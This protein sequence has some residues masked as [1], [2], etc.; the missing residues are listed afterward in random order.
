MLDDGL[1]RKYL[2]V[3]DSGHPR[4]SFLDDGIFR[5]TPPQALNDPFEVKPRVLLDEFADE[6]WAVARARG[7]EAG[8]SPD[9]D[10]TIRTFLLEAFP[11]QRFD[12][13][14][15]PGLYPA[16]I[17]ELRNEP[18]QTVAEIDAFRAA[19]ICATVEQ[20][21]N[22]RIG[23]FSWA[24][25]GHEHR[26]IVVGFDPKHPFLNAV[27]E[28]HQVEYRALHVA[29]SSNGELIRVAGYPLNGKERVPVQT[30]LRKSPEWAYEKEWRLLVPLARSDETRTMRAGQERIHLLRFP[31][32]AI[33]A[34]VLGARLADA[35]VAEVAIRVRK[36]PQLKH[37]AIHRAELSALDFALEALPI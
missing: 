37:V 31:D 34:L 1:L 6:D 33:R 9:D 36:N 12:E 35:Q 28:L 3:E 20:F 18:F 7:R 21:L 4:L 23:V 5:I 14:A 15:F 24:H 17:P 19:K 11:A 22:E 30:L 27:G 8:I 13:K 16:H 25:Y 32:S 10:E 2:G 29:I 26:G